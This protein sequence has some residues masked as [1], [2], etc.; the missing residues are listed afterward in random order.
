M[1]QPKNCG[2]NASQCFST[3]FVSSGHSFGCSNTPARR[4]Q[5][6]ASLHQQVG[7]IFFIAHWSHNV[8][9]A[10]QTFLFKCKQM[11]I[12][13][14]PLV[15]H[16]S[17]Q[18]LVFFSCSSSAILSLHKDG[19]GPTN[20]FPWERRAWSKRTQKHTKH[21]KDYKAEISDEQSV[22]NPVCAWWR[23]AAFLCA[24]FL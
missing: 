13:F 18:S 24:V 23:L 2:I 6:K 21:N 7:K 4:Q 8:S 17:V 15:I 1:I 19:Y 20:Y 5:C 12:G 11:Q 22:K 3:N 9:P 16:F 10:H 14:F